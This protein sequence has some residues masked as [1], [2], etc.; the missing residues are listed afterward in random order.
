MASTTSSISCTSVNINLA[1]LREVKCR[2]GCDE[3]A[4][5]V[6]VP[7]GCDCWKDPVQALC[8]QHFGQVQTCGRVNIIMDLRL[9][10]K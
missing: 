5:I 1:A 7:G 3:P 6:H 9:R 8:M 2:Y 10:K 4:M